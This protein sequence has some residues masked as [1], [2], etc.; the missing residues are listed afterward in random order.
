MKGSYFLNLKS[1]LLLSWVSRLDSWLCPLNDHLPSNLSS[2]PPLSPSSH[3]QNLIM[4]H[5]DLT[6]DC[7]PKIKGNQINTNGKRSWVW[8][9]FNPTTC[10]KKLQCTVTSKSGKEC[11]ALLARDVRSSTKGMSDHLLAK[12]NL[13][14]PNKRVKRMGM[15]DRFVETGKSQ[16]MVCTII[17][18]YIC[19]DSN[20]S[21]FLSTPFD[22]F[23]A[24]LEHC[25]FKD[26]NH[27][28][29]LWLWS[30][31]GNDWEKIL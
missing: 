4:N 18:Y 5:I 30:F 1:K 23:E 17:W 29:H 26:R 19:L 3:I 31:I 24:P 9:H 28:L 7:D 2:S 8:T 25:V 27:L 15:I 11:G 12:H 22:I 20:L 14:D 21:F 6:N 10:G 13:G 16:R